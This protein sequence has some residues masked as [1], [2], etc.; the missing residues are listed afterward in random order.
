[1]DMRTLEER[2][3]GKENMGLVFVSSDIDDKELG[4]FL[5]SLGKRWRRNGDISVGF[6][7]KM[8]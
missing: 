2:K 3:A 7:L 4:G 8:Q 6:R 1:M 5:E